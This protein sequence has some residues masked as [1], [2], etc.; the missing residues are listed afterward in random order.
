VPPLAARIEGDADHRRRRVWE[1]GRV[2]PRRARRAVVAIVVLY[3]AG[4]VAARSMGYKVG[5]ETPVRCRQGHVFTT[6]WIP[7]VSVKALRLGWQ[8]LQ[9]CPVGGHWSLV[10]PQRPSDLSAADLES[11]SHYHDLRAP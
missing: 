9:W 2:T 7:G 3:A 5:G 8:R 10:T 11:A 1:T 4:T 6:L